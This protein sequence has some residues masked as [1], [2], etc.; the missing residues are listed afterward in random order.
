[1]SAVGMVKSQEIPSEEQARL[2]AGTGS[3]SAP[4]LSFLTPEVQ[5]QHSAYNDRRKE[6]CL[7]LTPREWAGQAS[8]QVQRSAEMSLS[9]RVL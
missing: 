4:V 1:M 9:F 6:R 5:Y 2:R 8:H 7:M 3:L